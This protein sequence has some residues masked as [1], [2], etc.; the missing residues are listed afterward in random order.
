MSDVEIS[1]YDTAD[2]LM[3]EDDTAAY[4]EAAM[5]D[6]DPALVENAHKVVTRARAR[7]VAPPTISA[8]RA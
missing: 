1:H 6:G 3:T 7:M 5:E 4:L 8:P 2:Y